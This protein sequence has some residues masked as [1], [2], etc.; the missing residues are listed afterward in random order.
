[1]RAV[2]KEPDVLPPP[3]LGELRDR[4][5]TLLKLKKL[6]REMTN[7][8]LQLDARSKQLLA[9]VEQL[10][11]ELIDCRFENPDFDEQIMKMEVEILARFPEADSDK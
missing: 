7:E 4:K 11:R 1:M 10:L 2:A 5:V 9:D 3:E 8:G 6:T